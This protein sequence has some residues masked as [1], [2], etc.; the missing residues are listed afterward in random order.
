M[1]QKIVFLK[2][3]KKNYINDMF[4]HYRSVCSIFVMDQYVGVI[5]LVLDI[6]F[7][8]ILILIKIILQT[9][10]SLHCLVAFVE[11]LLCSVQNSHQVANTMLQ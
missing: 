10:K 2:L 7:M 3:E 5:L 4:A 11:D 8:Q 1:T 9:L 6:F